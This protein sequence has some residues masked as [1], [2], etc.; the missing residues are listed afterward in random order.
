[1]NLQNI[2]SLLFTPANKPER[3]EK[4]KI[5][6]ADG[7]I[8]DLEDSVTLAEKNHA[9]DI[10]IGYLKTYKKDNNFI[11]CLRINSLKTPAGIKDIT[12]LVE[13]HVLPDAIMLPKSEFA[14]EFRILDSLLGTNSIPYLALIETAE[15]LY[16]AKEIASSSKNLG[17][18]VF[19]GADLAADLQSKFSWDA[20]FDARCI[21][22][23]AAATMNLAALD[24]PYLNLKDID[25]TGIISE[26][27]KVKELGFTGKLSIHPKHIEPINNTFSPT[28]EEYEKA[29]KIVDIYENSGGNACEI[30]GKM[31]DVPVY[32]SAKRIVSL[33]RK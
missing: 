27:E 20:M 15:G 25:D 26:S 6:G 4:A 7:L 12:A 14:A 31:I 23:R 18:L 33:K 28:E 24:V 30:D 11:Q 1:M 9:R 5:V 2:R 8:I 29:K 17:A 22:V 16:N 32:K 13:N 19:G 3:F 21:I 10:V